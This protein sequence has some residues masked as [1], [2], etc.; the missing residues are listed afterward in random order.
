MGKI[1]FYKGISNE[2]ENYKGNGNLETLLK[3]FIPN[4]NIE[5]CILLKGGYKVDKDYIVKDEDIIFVKEIPHSTAVIGG[6]AIASALVGL[7][8][9]VYSITETKKAQK[10][11]EEAQR[12]ADQEKK[13]SDTM[14]KGT[15][16]LPFLSGAKNQSAL[17]RN[18]PYIMG[19]QYVVPYKL[20][21]GYYS[22]GGPN[23]EKQYWNCHFV[24]GYNNIDLE[25]INV[26][27]ATIVQGP[28]GKIAE[29]KHNCTGIYNDSENT[30]DVCYGTTVSSHYN[31]GQWLDYKVTSNLYGDK[32]P[33]D[34]N[35]TT[36]WQQGII[37]EV[38][39]DSF[40]VQICI[41]FNGLRKWVASETVT[42]TYYVKCQTLAEVIQ[43]GGQYKPMT[44]EVQRE[45]NDWRGK[46]VSFTVYGTTNLNE[47]TPTWQELG[48]ITTP[49]KNIG[50][51]YRIA[52]FFDLR[53]LGNIRD[54]DIALKIV[55]TTP[56][57]KEGE[58]QEEA[59]L[60]YI[61]CYHYNPNFTSS[62][63]ET[64]VI[65]T[66]WRQ[67]TTRIAV[68]LLA[69]ESIKDELDEINVMAFAKAKTF[70]AESNSPTND[71]SKT[72]NDI[73]DFTNNSYSYGMVIQTQNQKT[74]YI[75]VRG[76]GNTKNVYFNGNF[77]QEGENNS[78]QFLNDY[79]DGSFYS[80]GIL[81][82]ANGFVKVT[83]EMQIVEQKAN[84]DGWE[85]TLK[86]YNN[87]IFETG[88]IPDYKSNLTIKKGGSG[89]NNNWVTLKDV[90]D[91]KADVLRRVGNVIYGSESEL[92]L[93]FTSIKATAERD[94][95]TVQAFMEN[96]G[97]LTLFETPV[98]AIFE[99][100][101]DNGTT[102]DSLDSEG[103]TAYYK[104]NR[105][106]DGYL[107]K[108]DF[109]SWLL[110]ARSVNVNGK[111]NPSN[112]SA[113]VDVS[114]YLSWEINFSAKIN[115]SGRTCYIDFT[116]LNEH[117][118][119]LEY[120]VRIK[121]LQSNYTAPDNTEVEVLEDLGVWPVN[122][123]LS[124]IY[125]DENSYKKTEWDSEKRY[126]NG[127]SQTLPLV[128]QNYVINGVETPCPSV[129]NY[130]YQIRAMLFD[131][132]RL[133]HSS[134]ILDK[135]F[136]AKPTS[137]KDITDNAITTNKLAPNCVTY[138]K[139]HANVLSAEQIATY[140]MKTDEAYIGTIS[141][142]E[143]KP[144]NY[145]NLANGE[146][147]IGNDIDLEE[148]GSAQAQ[149]FH[150]KNG[151]IAMKIANFIMTSLSSIIKGLF[152]IQTSTGTDFM[153]VDPGTA[154]KVTI[155]GDITTTGI[156]QINNNTD[157]DGTT[158]HGALIIGSKTGPHVS[159]DN[160]EI[161][162]KKYV[163]SVH[164][165]YSTRCKRENN[166]V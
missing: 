38:N 130:L 29:G 128:G 97:E 110:R 26:G 126:L 53:D 30:V 154:K 108:D 103:F 119:R 5:K 150:F 134:D 99:I 61:N 68:K 107:E 15:E 60:S 124:A 80:F 74:Y 27:N 145:W 164:N 23:G 115:G 133:V 90:M 25:K 162:A 83:N 18:I 91:T 71:V 39:K 72:R 12:K 86:D 79:S 155:D 69:N 95:I 73:C 132:D 144:N 13:K 112:T 149:Y 51:T 153:T 9:T 65:E 159:I 37:K 55:R 50:S 102:W 123:D 113:N 138:D 139:I 81:E 8:A 166:C 106:E 48:T 36:Q 165:C 131:N 45:V 87:A 56:K 43:Y 31:E 49:E 156:V 66:E 77:S 54:K 141:G 33:H 146:F 116:S 16:Q 127:F 17:G 114:N 160:N 10:Q 22:I 92:P 111:E 105:T 136:S 3:D 93:P 76:E 59:Y 6:L 28:N 21:G 64:P 129:T 46:S 135:Y 20:G 78:S 143:E 151:N 84:A 122:D 57:E 52:R 32:L 100:S 47:E 67:K 75:K 152:K 58:S 104:F 163:L 157:V 94:G 24:V 7:G 63:A 142:D 19:N 35:D 1:R 96:V 101:K 62:Y 82:Q 120:E 148:T 109:N 125:T 137:A 140:G 98:R 14:G 40:R 88:T 70:I 121:R 161:M 44:R 89:S 42:E 118:G 2:I 41:E 147:R 4:L 117:Y 34:Q 85:L 11:M 158:S